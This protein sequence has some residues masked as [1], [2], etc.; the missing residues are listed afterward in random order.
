LEVEATEAKDIK[1]VVVTLAEEEKKGEK[2]VV[3]LREQ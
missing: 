2:D 1:I 3:L